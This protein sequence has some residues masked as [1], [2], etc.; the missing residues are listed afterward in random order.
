MKTYE[1]VVIF[2]FL[3]FLTVGF[4]VSVTAVFLIAYRRSDYP[5]K[6][7]TESYI[8]ESSRAMEKFSDYYEKPCIYFDK[9][10]KLL[11]IGLVTLVEPGINEP[12]IVMFKDYLNLGS[13]HKIDPDGVA[14]RFRTKHLE[15][16]ITLIDHN[17]NVKTELHRILWKLKDAGFFE[18]LGI[19]LIKANT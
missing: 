8:I 17:A 16:V 2:L 14:I 13:E 19:E 18:D 5:N 1:Q 9:N 11:R 15:K 6:G 7:F 10:E 3:I 4:I 12:C